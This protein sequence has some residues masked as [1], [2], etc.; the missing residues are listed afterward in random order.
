MSEQ[1]VQ[2]TLAPITPFY[3]A[4]V[5]NLRLEAEGVEKT[6]TLQ[7]L[8]SYAKKNMIETT[9]VPGSKK[10]FFVGSAFKAWLDQYVVGGA[11]STRTDVA[12]LA[13]Q[14]M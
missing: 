6:V 5:T 12:K 11:A 4:K 8:Y 2:A 10:I 7:M 9:T 1:P 14:Y 3:A 13:E